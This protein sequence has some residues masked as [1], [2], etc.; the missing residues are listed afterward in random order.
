MAT[1]GVSNAITRRELDMI[2]GTATGQFSFAGGSGANDM[3]EY[4]TCI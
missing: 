2:L 3:P 1:T 4:A